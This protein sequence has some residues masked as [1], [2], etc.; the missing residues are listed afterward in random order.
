MEEKLTYESAMQELEKTVNMLED[1]KLPLEKSLALFERG[2]RLASF[3]N[4]CLNNAEKKIER[5]TKIEED[6]KKEQIGDDV[7]EF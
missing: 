6:L 2:T 5:L 4:E 1:G 3:C 7:V